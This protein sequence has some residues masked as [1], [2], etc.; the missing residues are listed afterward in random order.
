MHICHVDDAD[1]EWIL[2]VAA[3]LSAESRLEA[4]FFSGAAALPTGRVDG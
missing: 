4:R 3:N 1:L 2:A